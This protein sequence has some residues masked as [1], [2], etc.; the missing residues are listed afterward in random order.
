MSNI[1]SKGISF[2]GMLTILFIGLKLTGNITWSWVW[3]LSP[4]WIPFIMMGASVFVALLCMGVA[5]FFVYLSTK[6]E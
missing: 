4:M 2:L 6:K 3:V 1:S 5:W